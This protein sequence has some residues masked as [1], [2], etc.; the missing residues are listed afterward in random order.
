MGAVE[1]IHGW[2]FVYAFLDALWT[3]HE[4][5]LVVTL[6]PFSNVEIAQSTVDVLLLLGLTIT[7]RS[8][9][10]HWV[11][12]LVGCMIEREKLFG[13][14]AMVPGESARVRR[15]RAWVDDRYLS[16]VEPD[17]LDLD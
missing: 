1:L 5:D 7:D 6:E 16:M 8:R 17:P 2:E 10:V 13:I 15:A 14:A 11:A 12:D 3:N 4:S 9:A